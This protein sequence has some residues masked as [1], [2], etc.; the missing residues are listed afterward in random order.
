MT[1]VIPLLRASPMFFIPPVLP[2]ELVSFQV[3]LVI[4][5]LLS[6]RVVGF[7]ANS[8]GWVRDDSAILHVE[9][10]DL[11]EDTSVRTVVSHE[12]SDDS[13]LFGG[14]HGVLGAWTVEV[15]L[16]QS[17]WVVVATILV[18]EALISL[19][20]IVVT[21]IGSRATGLTFDFAGVRSDLG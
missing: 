9:S 17:E 10:P 15:G 2:K 20:F 19:I 7:A 21:A 12:L 16:T 13:H 4:A 18:A 14:V 1:R 6:D 8:H 11:G 5:G 3:F